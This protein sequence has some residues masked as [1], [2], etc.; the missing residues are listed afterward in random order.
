M[1]SSRRYVFKALLVI[2]ITLVRAIGV[3]LCSG[4]R[5]PF[6]LDHGRIDAVQAHS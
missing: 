6:G 2:A 1:M 5:R 4:L 3:I